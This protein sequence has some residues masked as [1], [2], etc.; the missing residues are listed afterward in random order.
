MTLNAD[1]IRS[2][3]RRAHQS[4]MRGYQIALGDEYAHKLDGTDGSAAGLIQLCTRALSSHAEPV[5][6]PSDDDSPPTWVPPAPV[7]PSLQAESVKLAIPVEAAS[8]PTPEAF[9]D[10]TD[11]VTVDEPADEGEAEE[12]VEVESADVAKDPVPA[13]SSSSKRSSKRRRG[14]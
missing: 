5:A 2:L 7:A 9:V 10:V 8:V 12:T 13:A 3:L 1:E 14:K 4:A 6:P 11:E